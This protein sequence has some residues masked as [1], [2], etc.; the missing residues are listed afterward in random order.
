VAHLICNE[1]S[2]TSL[3]F[4]TLDLLEKETTTGVVIEFLDGA[5][6]YSICVLAAQVERR[7]SIDTENCRSCWFGTAINALMRKSLWK[8][9]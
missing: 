6:P 8:I 1:W 3:S 2:G 4:T 9:H 7:F 5:K